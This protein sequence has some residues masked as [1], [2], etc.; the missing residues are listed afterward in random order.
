MLKHTF[1]AR[2]YIIGSVLWQ[3]LHI[4]KSKR[5]LDVV[6]RRG[7]YNYTPTEQKVDVYTYVD[8][9]YIATNQT[10]T[11]ASFNC[12]WCSHTY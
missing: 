6:D 5:Y 12:S 7:L 9:G 10:L 11:F 2:L 1:R 3:R 8:A 4:C